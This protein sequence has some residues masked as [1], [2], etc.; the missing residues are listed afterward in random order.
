MKALNKYVLDMNFDQISNKILVG[1]KFLS[2]L[3]VQYRKR[4]LN[5]T[6]NNCEQF[7]VLHN[8]FKKSSHH[9]FNEFFFTSKN[10]NMN[11][12]IEE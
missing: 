1:D 2:R 5:L 7:L 3:V 8:C 11:E 9:F 6:I 12:Q 10:R 4:Y